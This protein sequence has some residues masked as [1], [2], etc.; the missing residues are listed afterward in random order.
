VSWQV[1]FTP[2]NGANVGP[3]STCES[4]NLTITN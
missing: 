4:S 2:S 1:T 3:S